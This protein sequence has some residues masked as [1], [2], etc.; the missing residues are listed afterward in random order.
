M[1]DYYRLTH[2]LADLVMLTTVPSQDNLNM[3]LYWCQQVS[4]QLGHP[5]IVEHKVNIFSREPLYSFLKY[6]CPF[7]FQAESCWFLFGSKRLW[8]VAALNKW[9]PCLHAFQQWIINV[10]GVLRWS[11]C[12]KYVM[13]AHPKIHY[14]EEEVPVNP[15]INSKGPS[16]T[17]DCTRKQEGSPRH[18]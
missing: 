13:T 15:C 7:L 3:R 14:C 16:T 18:P 1:I 5:V 10:I 11:R 12:D 9:M 8:V 17:D 6:I 2:L 4:K